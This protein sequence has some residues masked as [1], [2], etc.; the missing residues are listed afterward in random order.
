M[1]SNWTSFEINERKPNA[2]GADLF[3]TQLALQLDLYLVLEVAAS[4]LRQ[5][6]GGGRIR[7]PLACP[8]GNPLQDTRLLCG[9]RVLLSGLVLVGG[10]SPKPI[11]VT[12]SFQTERVT[13]AGSFHL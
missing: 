1:L 10:E 7:F 2:L 3:G 9:G 12:Y 11:Q 4:G 13:L 5:G 6:R 8:T